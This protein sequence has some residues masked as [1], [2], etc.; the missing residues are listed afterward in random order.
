VTD[1][2]MEQLSSIFNQINNANIT[3][4]SFTQK[5]PTLEDVFYTIIKE[6]AK[7]D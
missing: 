5:L 4:T 6:S 3:I 2:S 1:G 7:V